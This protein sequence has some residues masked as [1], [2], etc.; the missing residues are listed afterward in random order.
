[1]SS[2]ADLYVESNRRRGLSP[3]M[4]NVTAPVFASSSLFEIL[5]TTAF[6][7]SSPQQPTISWEKLS[8]YP[9]SKKFRAGWTHDIEDGP[10][11]EVLRLR[12]RGNRRIDSPPRRR[13]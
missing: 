1:M 7:V 9:A 11:L 10:E 4:R 12:R 6:D 8:M 3:T 5:S 13:S 2:N